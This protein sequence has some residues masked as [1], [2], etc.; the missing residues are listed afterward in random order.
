MMFLKCSLEPLPL[1]LATLPEPRA[2]ETGEARPFTLGIMCLE[3]PEQPPD[4]YMVKL[5]S[6][7]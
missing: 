6:C 7:P 2:L 5:C 4:T 3:A 1:N